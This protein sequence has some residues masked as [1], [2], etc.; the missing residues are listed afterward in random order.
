MLIWLTCCCRDEEEMLQ[1][2]RQQAEVLNADDDDDDE[3]GGG[4]DWEELLALGGEGVEY[5]V[6]STGAMV[7][8]AGAKQL[9]N[10]YCQKLPSDK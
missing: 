9:L 7:N 5:R 10:M 3:G 8:L 2:A 1:T 4:A 6:D